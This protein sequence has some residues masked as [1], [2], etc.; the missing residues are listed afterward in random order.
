MGPPETTAWEYP[1]ADDSWEAEFRE[2]LDDI[3]LG[4]EPTPGLAD[5]QAALRVVERVYEESGY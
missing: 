5:A 4:R 3:R 1:M 2:F